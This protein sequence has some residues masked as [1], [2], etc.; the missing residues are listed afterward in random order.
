SR[1]RVLTRSKFTCS[2]PW[3]TWIW[4][5]R[6]EVTSARPCFVYPS[7]PDRRPKIVPV[8]PSTRYL[9]AL[10]SAQAAGPTELGNSPSSSPDV[11]LWSFPVAGVCGALQSAL[12]LKRCQAYA[13]VEC[14][15]QPKSSLAA[16]FCFVLTCDSQT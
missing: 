7:A 16:P 6:K 10:R 1:R 14:Q 12:R 9:P 5:H 8:I 11:T 4:R 15:F 3:K 2:L 13:P